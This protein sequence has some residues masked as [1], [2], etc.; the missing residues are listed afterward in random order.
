MADL[1]SIFSRSLA[2]A[3]LSSA[4]RASSTF[5]CREVTSSSLYCSITKRTNCWRARKKKIKHDR[6]HVN[7]WEGGLTC[8]TY[9]FA[10]ITRKGLRALARDA[11]GL[12]KKSLTSAN[13]ACRKPAPPYSGGMCC[14]SCGLS[15]SGSGACASAEMIL[16]CNA[17]T[18]SNRAVR[19][20]PCGGERL[21]T[22][23][24]TRISPNRANIR[25]V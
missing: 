15:R 10:C 20:C 7:K 14:P 23:M 24:R 8:V 25:E 13:V 19:N 21:S 5:P 1:W 11:F 6:A 17:W 18:S 3:S 16:A 12:S 22:R 4:T 2:T 9:K